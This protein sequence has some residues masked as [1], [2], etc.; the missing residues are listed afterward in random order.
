M[1]NVVTQQWIISKKWLGNKY[2][3][4]LVLLENGEYYISNGEGGEFSEVTKDYAE[5]LINRKL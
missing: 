2:Y 1:N 4:L 3:R 5:E